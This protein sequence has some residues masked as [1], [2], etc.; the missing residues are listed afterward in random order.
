[1]PVRLI[2]KY[3]NSISRTSPFYIPTFTLLEISVF[4]GQLHIYL[5]KN[6]VKY[7]YLCDDSMLGAHLIAF[8][9]FYNISIDI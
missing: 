5:Y 6:P 2:R 1:M 3:Y 4:V 7:T 9:V 8:Q